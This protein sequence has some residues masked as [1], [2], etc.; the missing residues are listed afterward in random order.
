[1]TPIYIHKIGLVNNLGEDSESAWQKA[2]DGTIS[3]SEYLDFPVAR[4]SSSAFDQYKPDYKPYSRLDRSTQL[5]LFAADQ[6]SGSLR[7]GLKTMTAIGTSRGATDTWE[8][9]YSEYASA[10][11]TSPLASPTTTAGQLASSVSA[12]LKLEH[13]LDMDQSITCASGLRAVAD[14]CAWL[15]AG[16]VDS[17]IAGGAEAPLTPFTVAQM[18]ALKILGPITEEPCRSLDPQLNHN[19]M[20]LGEGAVLFH[21]SKEPV[22]EGVRIVGVGFGTDVGI[23][24]TGLSEIGECLQSAMKMAIDMAGWKRPDAIV[25]HAPGT[26]KGDQSEMRAIRALFNDVPV[27][28]TKYRTGH[29]FGSSGPMSIWWAE[30]MMKNNNWLAPNWLPQSEPKNLNRI[31][32]NAVGFGANAVSLALEYTK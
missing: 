24:A 13:N 27:T 23:S 31:L 21:L 2:T 12:H 4:V 15:S 14:A 18:Q 8:K 19:T 10:G 32:V 22:E 5:A 7:P 17:A 11:R 6:L 3:F 29:G 9:A 28:S 30:Q 26:V 1:M 16:W 25:A 20:V